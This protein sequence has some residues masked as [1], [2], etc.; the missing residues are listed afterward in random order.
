MTSAPVA[1]S[2][3]SE[4]TYPLSPARARARSMSFSSSSFAAPVTF[5]K[6]VFFSGILPSAMR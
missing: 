3:D 6:R 2:R 4:V 1:L 5:R